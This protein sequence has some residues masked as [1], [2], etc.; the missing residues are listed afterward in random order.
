M[1]A[2]IIGLRDTCRRL[3]TLEEAIA[4]QRKNVAAETDP[5]RAHAARARLARL[6]GELDEFLGAAQIGV[7]GDV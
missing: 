6:L 4:T 7:A 2:P 1:T 5:R 3:R